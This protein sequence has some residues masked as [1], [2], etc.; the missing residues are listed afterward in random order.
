MSSQPP[1]PRVTS[2]RCVTEVGA[3]NRR[4]VLEVTRA[5][6]FEGLAFFP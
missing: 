1:Q 4:I 2:R 6:K 5:P 3:G